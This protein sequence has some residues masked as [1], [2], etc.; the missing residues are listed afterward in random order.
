MPTPPRRAVLH[1]WRA[2]HLVEGLLCSSAWATAFPTK[3][4]H[5]MDA[6]SWGGGTGVFLSASPQPLCRTSMLLAGSDATKRLKHRLYLKKRLYTPMD[7]KGLKHSQRLCQ[8]G[9][10]GL[11]Y[12][13]KSS[14]SCFLCAWETRLQ[15]AG[16]YLSC[17][18]MEWRGTGKLPQ[19]SYSPW[20]CAFIACS[21]RADCVQPAAMHCY[22]AVSH[23]IKISRNSSVMLKIR[24]D[25]MK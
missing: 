4:N 19:C 9:A 16:M 18:C 24:G 15:C 10:Q 17:L 13:G 6:N 23:S 25:D 7:R 14:W 20:C 2:G 1:L 11:I 5:R 22:H 3:Q 21:S 8:A 12:I